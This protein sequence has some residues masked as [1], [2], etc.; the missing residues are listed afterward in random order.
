MTLSESQI[1][2]AGLQY[3]REYYRKR[4]A[5]GQIQVSTGVQDAGKSQ[6][7]GFI[8]FRQR[9]GRWFTATLEAS[10]YDTRQE[11]RY[12]RR[13]AQMFLDNLLV[14]TWI[15]AFA[16]AANMMYPVVPMLKNGPYLPLILIL[17]VFTLSFFGFNLLTTNWKRYR[18][19]QAIEQFK[20]HYADEQ[21][22]VAASSL[23]TDLRDPYFLELKR[24][25]LRYGMGLIL[26]D[27]SLQQH[28]HLTPTRENSAQESR[29]ILSRFPW[30]KQI[31]GTAA[32]IL[33][34][35]VMWYRE[36]DSWRYR[37][38]V[39]KDY[40]E[41]L[42]QQIRAFPREPDTYWLDTP[43]FR[44]EPMDTKAISYLEAWQQDASALPVIVGL[45]NS[46]GI[47]FR[48][49][50][51]IV[52]PVFVLEAGYYTTLSGV[53]ERIEQYQQEGVASGAIRGDCYSTGAS[54]YLFYVGEIYASEAEATREK[55]NKSAWQDSLT[56]RQVNE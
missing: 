11:V 22:I 52:G 42:D 25:C 39:L 43:F 47:V 45:P 49:C 8:T 12:I 56:L 9:D 33:L 44:P 34:I 4:L 29:H 27:E 20:R 23:F 7:D 18:E 50:D 48:A 54:G 30:I 17:S 24:Q 32:A 55:N 5:E 35:G 36:Y 14:S 28:T 31:T 40:A 51:W 10:S 13:K 37:E 21:W 15:T 41:T 16:G 38:V 53:L 46:R 19:I 2:Q 3:L 6:A 26:I 1:L